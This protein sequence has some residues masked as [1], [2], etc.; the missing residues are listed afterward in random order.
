MVV[1]LR[2][3]ENACAREAM[4]SKDCVTGCNCSPRR[5]A[6]IA[7]IWPAERL[8]KLA[9]VGLR[10]LPPPRQGSHRKTVGGEP[11]LGLMCMSTK[12]TH[13]WQ[14]KAFAC[15]RSACNKK[16][17]CLKLQD[18]FPESRFGSGELQFR[19]VFA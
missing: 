3:N 16:H 17:K 13:F 14:A 18:Y 19:N 15:L 8:D 5:T 1:A 7:S 6:R 4:T 12:L 10:T 9:R 11:R 2:L